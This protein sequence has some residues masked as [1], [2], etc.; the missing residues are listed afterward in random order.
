MSPINKI[1]FGSV[2]CAAARVAALAFLAPAHAQM[3]G[4][5]PAAAAALAHGDAR[6]ARSTA[7]GCH[8]V[9]RANIRLPHADRSRAF[10]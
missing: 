7:A 5:H 8:G 6:E 10:R 4:T 2:T 3:P 1:A 9:C